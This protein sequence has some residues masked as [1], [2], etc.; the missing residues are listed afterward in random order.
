MSLLKKSLFLISTILVS[1]SLFSCASLQKDNIVTTDTFAQ[2][3]ALL[4]I[5]KDFT[6]MDAQMIVDNEKIMSTAMYAEADNLS[7]TIE[8]TIKSSGVDAQLISRLYAI[9]GL[10]S[11][12]Q[13]KKQKAKQMYQLSLS[14]YKGDSYTIVLGS[15]LDLVSSLDDVNI[16]SGS[17]QSGLL[18]LEQGIKYYQEGEYSKAVALLDSSFLILP[19]FYKESYSSIRQKSWNLRSNTSATENTTILSI[20]GKTQFTVG[21]ML[22]VTQD[23]SDLLNVVNGGSKYTEND[24]FNRVKNAGYLDPSSSLAQSKKNTMKKNQLLTREICARFLWNIYS[25]KKDLKSQ[26]TKYSATF[27]VQK[28]FSPIADVDIA[29]EDFDAILGTVENE[30]MALPDGVNFNPD[31]LI[32]PADFNYS[33]Q[34]IK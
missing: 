5:E 33:L 7:R 14:T 34:K 29:N 2:N 4:D 13:N 6:N 10:V 26:K 15:R 27:R 32:S 8:A 21:E 30:I 22:L 16:V 31:E 1:I 18:K 17:N 28:G 25:E 20:L 3:Q 24:L 19:D 9:N 11:L 23:T 12:L